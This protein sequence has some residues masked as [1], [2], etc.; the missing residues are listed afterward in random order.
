ME[1]IRGTTPTLIFTFDTIDVDD[2]SVAYLLVKQSGNTVIEKT[3]EDSTISEEK[4]M[5][6]FTQAETLS[7]AQGVP[8]SVVLDW[9]TI[10]GIRGRSNIYRFDVKQAGVDEVI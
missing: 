9:K 5:F 4:L 8:A 3:F 6:S 10:A 2:I 1:I 7:L